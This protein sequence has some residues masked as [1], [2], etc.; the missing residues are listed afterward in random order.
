VV[1]LGGS[2]LAAVRELADCGLSVVGVDAGRVAA[3]AAGRNGGLLLGGGA[4][5]L[6]DAIARWGAGPA[7]EL[8]RT[9]LHELDRLA[10]AFGPQL[11]RRIGSIRL[12][13]LPGAP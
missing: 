7:V 12:A 1:G 4:P 9:T 2:G 10:D 5:F 8:Y 13:G 3:G 11:V 6:H